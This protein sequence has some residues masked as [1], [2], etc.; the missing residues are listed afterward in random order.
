MDIFNPLVSYSP[1]I[2][3]SDRL[4]LLKMKTWHISFVYAEVRYRGY[5]WQLSFPSV[6]SVF[7]EMSNEASL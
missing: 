3:L 2:A 6:L 7:L 1:M 5:K 4:F